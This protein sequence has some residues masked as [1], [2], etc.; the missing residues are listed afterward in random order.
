MKG[1]R[2]SGRGLWR[3]LPA[4]PEWNVAVFALLLNFPWEL[5]Q[6]P[7]FAGMAGA[8]HRQVIQGCLQATLGDA[9]IMLI[10]YGVVS[11]TASD[12]HWMLKPSARQLAL[13]I[14]IGVAIT[15]AIEWLATRGHWVQGWSYSQQMPVVPGLGIGLAPL[16]Q[17]IVLPL[18]V[19]WF[20][21]RQLSGGAACRDERP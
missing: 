2:R 14:A 16:A 17:W 6:V 7:L 12:R 13:F 11:L 9:V 1:E 3:A 8:L 20:V 5:L 21:R 18:L 4:M 19:A 10:S 15:V